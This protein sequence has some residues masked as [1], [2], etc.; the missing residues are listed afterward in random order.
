ML[1]VNKSRRQDVPRGTSIRRDI[2]EQ[3]DKTGDDAER[4][5][6]DVTDAGVERTRE[7]VASVTVVETGQGQRAV[8]AKEPS[9]MRAA[10]RGGSL[11]TS[12]AGTRSV[13][14]LMSAGCAVG[15]R[16]ARTRHSGPV[17]RTSMR[18]V[19]AKRRG[20]EASIRPEFDVS[21]LR[22]PAS[23]SENETLWPRRRTSMR[24]VNA[25]HRGGLAGSRAVPTLMSAGA[26]RR[27]G[28]RTRH[29][30]LGR[31]ASMRG[32]NAKRRGGLAGSRPVPSLM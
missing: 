23:R 31:R 7:G 22:S 14:T 20:E 1:L 8:D 30:G 19:N 3:R 21:G 25:K 26:V 17:R 24:G 32:V 13:P 4:L 2:D 10:G 15:R 9:R 11:A 16:G 5:Y 27:R 18:G 29:S 28:A 6:I 12:L